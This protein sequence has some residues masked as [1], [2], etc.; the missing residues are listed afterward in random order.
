[1]LCDQCS[2][3]TLTF[4]GLCVHMCVCGMTMSVCRGLY[5][6]HSFIKHT[7]NLSEALFLLTGR[8]RPQNRK[9]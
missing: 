4:L 9:M 2:M 5:F 1:M 3:H 8:D 7:L 6:I